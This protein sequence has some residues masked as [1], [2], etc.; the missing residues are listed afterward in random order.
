MDEPHGLF[1]ARGRLL[2]GETEVLRAEGDVLRDGLLEELLLGVL[3]DHA[4]LEAHGARGR[5]LFLG[6]RVD[7]NAVDEHAAR[8]RLQEAGELLQE[9]RLARAR[10]ARN[11]RPGALLNGD[12]DILERL[13]LERRAGHIGVGDVF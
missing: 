3:E 12:R 13:L 4:D 8:R 2:V 10:M 5:A 7:V 6:L 1:D 9:R 11:G